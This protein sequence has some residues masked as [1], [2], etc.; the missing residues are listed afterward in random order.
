MRSEKRAGIK[1]QG[2]SE[3]WMER[4]GERIRERIEWECG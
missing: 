2:R 3:N 1:G 4:G